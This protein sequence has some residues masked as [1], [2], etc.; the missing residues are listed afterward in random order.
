MANHRRKTPRARQKRISD[1]RKQG[2]PV[3]RDAA[4]RGYKT[5]LERRP[6]RRKLNAALQKF[7]DPDFALPKIKHV[8]RW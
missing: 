6:A 2:W 1:K 3:Y 7:D 5:V 4:S 8:Y